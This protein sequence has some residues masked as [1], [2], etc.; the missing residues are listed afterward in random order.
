MK[1][2]IYQKLTKARMMILEKELKKSATNNFAK[3]KYMEL[4]DIIPVTEKI[5][6]EIGITVITSFTDDLATTKVI[7][8]DNIEE[9]IEFTSP[10]NILLETGQIKGAQRIGALHTY[11]RRYML[12]LVF[13]IME[14]DAIDS[15]EPESK[16]KPIIKKEIKNS[17][18][19]EEKQ[20][21]KNEFIELNK[22]YKFTKEELKK[23]TAGIPSNEMSFK[24]WEDAIS[25]SQEIILDKVKNETVND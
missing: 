5:C 7:N 6:N 17:K 15:Q 13:E 10:F 20:L 25:N 21:L 24:N 22:K 11:F 2:N 18:E 9:V 8:H 19:E 3:F 4:T 16:S 12:M 14:H 23:I 1:E